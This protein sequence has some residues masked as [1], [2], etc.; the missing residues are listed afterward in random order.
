MKAS[1]TLQMFTGT[2]VAFVPFTELTTALVFKVRC[3]KITC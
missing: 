2:P 1:R 3:P